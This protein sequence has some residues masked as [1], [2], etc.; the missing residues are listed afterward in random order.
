MRRPGDD[1]LIQLEVDGANS[2]SD[3]ERVRLLLATRPDLAA[4][5]ESM[6]RLARTL[7]RSRRL[8]P[9][10]GFSDGVMA[11]IRNREPVEER[12]PTWLETLRAVLF[13]HPILAYACVLTLG[14][15][16]GALISQESKLFSSSDKAALSGTSLN[17]D[18]LRRPKR[19]AAFVRQG[20]RGEASTTL[21]DG[22][23]VVDLELESVLSVDVR[24]DGLSPRGFSQDRPGEGDVVMGRQDIR[25][26][27]APGRCRYTVSFG[28]G[29]PSGRSLSLLLGGDSIPI[30]MPE[31]P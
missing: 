12:P 4:R 24:I 28:S 25:F 21:R 8:D 23:L 22:L 15:A 14:L 9:P 16:L 27:H 2:A 26:R 31:E 30:P 6:S 29:E 3:S 11:S 18:R 20:I 10:P 5:L 13:P 17:P 1:E 7:E 19:A